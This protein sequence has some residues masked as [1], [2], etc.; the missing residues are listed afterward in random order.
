MQQYH[1]LCFAVRKGDGELLATLNEGLSQVISNGTRERLREKWIAPTRDERAER[2][3]QL[4][5]AVLGALSAAGLVGYVW[6]RTLRRQ[7][8]ARTESLALANQRQQE[9]IQLRQETEAQLR[10]SEESLSTTLHS[11][12][13][14]V[15]ATDAEG[16]VTRMNPTAERLTGWPLD[17]ARGEQLPTVFRIVNLDT[18]MTV[19]NPVQKVME[20]GDVVGPTHD[21]QKNLSQK[22][23]KRHQKSPF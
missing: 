15:I 10:A 1:D 18:R 5:A 4:I 2:N 16:R 11:I 7:V 13:D 6:I 20:C 3:R 12:G 22:F 14:A 19:D 21:H 23:R 17:D 8:K 9:E